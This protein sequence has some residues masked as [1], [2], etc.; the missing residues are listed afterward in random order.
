MDLDALKD[1]KK[2]LFWITRFD[3]DIVEI[4]NVTKGKNISY[5][6]YKSTR[7]AIND[8]CNDLAINTLT[9]TMQ[10][11]VIKAISDYTD[12]KHTTTWHKAC[13]TL[14]TKIYSFVIC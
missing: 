9:S 7:E 11:L 13:S 5:D 4:Y 3:Q 12:K 2:I 1:E 14:P 6:Q 8:I 10:G